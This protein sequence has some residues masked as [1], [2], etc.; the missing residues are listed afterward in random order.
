[1][2]RDKI[3]KLFISTGC[4]IEMPD[5]FDHDSL[6]YFL[7]WNGEIKYIQVH[8]QDKHINIINMYE[9][10]NKK[11]LSQNIQ[12]PEQYSIE[13]LNTFGKIA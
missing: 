9:N 6:Q 13:F 7:Q 4:G 5:W 3:D 10:E 11:L 2:S 8:T 1:M 12:N